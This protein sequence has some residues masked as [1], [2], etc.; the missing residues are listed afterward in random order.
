MTR[1]LFFAAL[2]VSLGL[3]ACVRTI[4]M[5]GT[6]N[7][8]GPGTSGKGSGG[9]APTGGSMTGASTTTGNIGVPCGTAVVGDACGVEG[10]QCGGASGTSCTGFMLVCHNGVWQKGDY[11]CYMPCL[12]AGTWDGVSGP[13]GAN[14]SKSASYEF[15]PGSD[16]IGGQYQADPVATEFMHG[17]YSIGPDTFTIVTGFG[18][19]PQ[20]DPT[21]MATYSL[22]FSPDCQTMTLHTMTDGC[23]GARLYLS[24]SSQGTVL[25]RRP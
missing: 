15:S 1:H 8:G 4:E 5:G 20:C 16:W 18:M 21:A 25:K 13:D 22:Q 9:T 6:G 14:P 23:T 10:E 3:V 7:G 19:G 17:T 2:A 12:V 24:A 11:Q